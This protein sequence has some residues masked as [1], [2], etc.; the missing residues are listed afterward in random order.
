[1]SD[2]NVDNKNYRKTSI[3]SLNQLSKLGYHIPIYKNINYVYKR[4]PWHLTTTL[5]SITVSLETRELFK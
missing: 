3:V 1:M 5:F 4:N 2:L